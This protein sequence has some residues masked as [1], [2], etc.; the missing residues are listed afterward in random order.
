MKSIFRVSI[1]VELSFS[2]AKALYTKLQEVDIKNNS[3]NDEVVLAFT[4]EL[5]VNLNKIHGEV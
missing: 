5:L 4:N 3:W 1:H 2:E